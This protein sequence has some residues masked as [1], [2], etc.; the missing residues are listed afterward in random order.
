M[1][2]D[3]Q[4]KRVMAVGD[5]HGCLTPFL[6][7]YERLNI[8]DDDLIIFLGDYIDRGSESLTALEWIGRESLKPNVIALRGN[9]EQTL[10]DCIAGR[11][12]DRFYSLGIGT[13]RDVRE[14][15]KSDPTLP[16]RIV[17]TIR[18][19]PLYHRLTID[20]RE[21]IFCHAGVDAMLDPDPPIE[22]Q[23]PDRIVW[24]REEFYRHYEGEA[25]YVVGHTPV[26]FLGQPPFPIKFF[27]DRNIIMMDTGSCCVESG[28]I[29]C[30][31]IISGE[32]W[33]TEP[34]G[35]GALG[36]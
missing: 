26:Q 10:L 21:Y 17:Q 15:A 32:F 31:D 18:R 35:R 1:I 28:R 16:L 24:V 11:Y 8:T 34:I 6:S 22:L 25:I 5:I 19:M 27:N 13:I 12:A 4:Y 29:S 33:Q 3:R 2:M 14:A 36:F 23:E 7:M 20:G 30:L 9:H